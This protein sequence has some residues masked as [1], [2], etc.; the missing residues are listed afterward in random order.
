[1]EGSQPKTGMGKK[2]KTPSEKKKLKTEEKTE[3]IHQ[4][5]EHLLTCSRP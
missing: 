2:Q 4:V 5:V 3:G 1:M